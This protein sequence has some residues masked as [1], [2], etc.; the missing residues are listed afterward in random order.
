MNNTRSSFYTI[1]PL[2]IFLLLCNP[3]T[4]GKALK[5]S[6]SYQKRSMA[7]DS[8]I[9]DS[10]FIIKHRN[11]AYY[12]GEFKNGKAHKGYFKILISEKVVVDYYE[13]GEKIHQY[14]NDYLK[15][16]LEEENNY[17]ND[18]GIPSSGAIT[19]LDRTSIYKEGRI[20]TG[21]E[22]SEIKS[23]FVTK[24]IESGLVTQIGIDVFA[25]NYF[26]RIT[27]NEINRAI[28]LTFLQDKTSKVRIKHEANVI[29]CSLLKGSSIIGYKTNTFFE[30]DKVPK[31]SSI[32]SSISNNTPLTV[33]MH[34]EG[35]EET[36]SANY[37][38]FQNI[39]LF[40]F[41]NLEDFYQ[42]LDLN[43][44]VKDENTEDR[45]MLAYV[46]T[47][48]KAKIENG[49]YWENKNGGQ[50]SE[51]I[52]GKFLGITLSSLADFE[53]SVDLFF[54]KMYEK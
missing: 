37:D 52:K 42:K 38:F 26:N 7:K 51:H 54:N 45:F 23:G 14:S 53:S 8:I 11:A 47:N 10:S 44:K 30:F 46:E 20:L 49:I 40:Q 41:D 50:N 3:I 22:Y 2:C 25:M 1:T 39:S 31:N 34:K 21:Y 4:Y 5:N 16:L 17:L 36:E 19:L 43:E 15:R 6:I 9:K 24:K 48:A 35:S 28:E 13:K 29:T 12:T 33:V 27:I 18:D 32:H